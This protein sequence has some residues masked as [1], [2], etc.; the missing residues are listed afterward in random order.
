MRVRIVSFKL[1]TE[2]FSS[3]DH[4]I[5][6]DFVAGGWIIDSDHEGVLLR[7]ADLSA[8]NLFLILHL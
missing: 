8:F 4:Q 3:A 6:L 1:Q 5:E 7:D 2:D